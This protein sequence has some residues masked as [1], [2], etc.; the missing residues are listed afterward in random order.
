MH[1]LLLAEFYSTPW[2]VLLHTYGV[3]CE[4]LERWAPACGLSA[5]EIRAAVGDAPEWRMARRAGGRRAGRA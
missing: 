3:M 4:V 2:A 5:E 1:Q